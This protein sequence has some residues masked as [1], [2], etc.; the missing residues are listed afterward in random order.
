M[1]ELWACLAAMSLMIQEPA[2]V[3]YICHIRDIANAECRAAELA[4][5]CR[6]PNEAENILLAA[7]QVYKAIMMWIDLYQFDRCLDLAVKFK[8]HVDTVLYFRRKYLLGIERVES[9]K[10]FLQYNSTV[11]VDEEGILAK[12]ASLS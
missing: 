7:N 6:Q 8:T 5:F 12:I 1:T 3:Q 4:L 11:D 9:D 2:K 10:R